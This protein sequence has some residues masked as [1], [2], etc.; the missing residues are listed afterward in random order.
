[1]EEKMKHF[2]LM[3]LITLLAFAACSNEMKLTNVPDND[4]GK[5]LQQVP[6]DG[7]D[8][9]KLVIQYEASSIDIQDLNNIKIKE[10]RVV[11]ATRDK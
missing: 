8:V 10:I 11:N 7:H 4:W 1:M 9:M 3:I 2:K 6:S 5:F